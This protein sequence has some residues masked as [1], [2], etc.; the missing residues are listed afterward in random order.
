MEQF[1]AVDDGWTKENFGD[2]VRFSKK[3]S[4]FERG[5]ET[6]WMKDIST[7]E[8]RRTDEDRD[9][10][11]RRVIQ[12]IPLYNTDVLSQ[13]VSTSLNGGRSEIEVKRYRSG[14]RTVGHTVSMLHKNIQLV[15][16]YDE[17]G[18]LEEI[19]VLH[20]SGEMTEMDSEKDVYTTLE[21]L[22]SLYKT[23]G[24][25]SLSPVAFK[26]YLSLDSADQEHAQLLFE[27]DKKWTDDEIAEKF[28]NESP[29]V[30]EKA[31]QISV[32]ALI[33][34]LDRIGVEPDIEEDSDFVS[35]MSRQVVS[36]MDP[37]TVGDDGDINLDMFFDAYSDALDRSL[38]AYNFTLDLAGSYSVVFS[39]DD[40]E[41][42]NVTALDDESNPIFE[43]KEMLSDSGVQFDRYR[44][45]IDITE[46]GV[47]VFVVDCITDTERIS[48]LFENNIDIDALESL[49]T[50]EF[51]WVK[52]R[53]VVE[54]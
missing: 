17:S 33:Q 23:Y 16:E 31:H 34:S 28:S 7:G 14:L 19:A 40:N 2:A 13:S 39:L 3:Y 54:R 42:Q 49:I 20:I 30:L 53:E 52:L 37:S 22:W 45:R 51:D 5:I 24:S 48:F 46:D 47:R 29:D 43:L 15:S 10:G 1:P 25:F 9:T 38:M 36:M 11:L 41:I 35:Y 44:Y 8:I 32:I 12:R 27:L 50:S 21:E 18:A 6:L 26:E 4:D